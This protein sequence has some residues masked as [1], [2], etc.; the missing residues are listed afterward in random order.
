MPVS[1]GSCKVHAVGSGTSAEAVN[2][3]A[4]QNG[5]GQHCDDEAA[6]EDA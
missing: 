1:E 4:H 6:G 5:L 3:A 2:R